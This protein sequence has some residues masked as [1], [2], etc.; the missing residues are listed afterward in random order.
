MTRC[1]VMSGPGVRG[2][3]E[4]TKHGDREREHSAAGQ[5]DLGHT[6]GCAGGVDQPVVFAAK[7][8]VGPFYCTRDAKA[9]DC[10]YWLGAMMYRFGVW[11][12]FFTELLKMKFSRPDCGMNDLG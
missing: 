1:G 7:H 5:A 10:C 9:A 4:K 6:A 2:D 8:C 11:G 12:V 3:A